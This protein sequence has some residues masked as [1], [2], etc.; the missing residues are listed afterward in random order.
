MSMHRQRSRARRPEPE[1]LESRRLL[2]KTIS[3]VDFDGDT[4]VLRLVGAGDMSVVQQPASSTSTTPVP[5]GTPGSIQSITVLGGDPLQTRVIGKVT[6]GEDG[7]GKVFFQNFTEVGGQGNG[8]AASLGIYAVDMPDFWLGQTGDATTNST[9]SITIPDGVVTLRFGGA[10]VTFAPPGITPPNEG[11]T[12][13]SF[14]I[15]LGLPY[16][17]GTSVIVDSMIT[18]AVAGT[19][20]TSNPNPAPIQFGVNVT[21]AGR[22]N[23]FQA[24]TIEGNPDDALAPSGFQSGGGTVVIS[25]PV[26]SASISASIGFVRVG[27]NATNFSVQSGDVISNF[28]IGGETNHVNVLAVGGS[29]NM[30]FGKGM[31]NVSILTHYIET[32][33]ANRGAVG[34]SVSVDRNIGRVTIGGDVVN[35]QILSGYEQGLATTFSN[36]QLPTTQS[37]PQPGGAINNVLIAG[38]VVD[39]IFAASVL[40][41]EGQFDVPETLFYPHSHISAKVEGTVDNTNVTPNKPNQ[42]FYAKTVKIGNGPVIPPAVPELPFPHPNYPPHGSRVVRGLQ[43]PTTA[44]DQTTSAQ[45]AAR[46]AARAEARRAAARGG[47]NGS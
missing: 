15:S 28:F 46:A 2:A 7:D 1:G 35:S 6:K 37:T 12:S 21:V 43:P 47:P 5:L 18:D 27:G 20:T 41:F 26:T 44:A 8:T 33:Q 38:D 31:D 25:A 10:D 34:A 14:S 40:P 3:G 16:S 22:L 32:L 24:N 30:Q 45:A 9:P 13:S 19:P 17:R 42:A 36:Q 11:T 4:W 23:V 39:S 29:R